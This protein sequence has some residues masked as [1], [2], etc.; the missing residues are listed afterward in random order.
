[1]RKYRVLIVDDSALMGEILTEILNSD[2]E[3]EVVGAAADPF[4]AR[5]LI[6]NFTSPMFL[7][8]TLKCLA[9]MG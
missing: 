4:I 2:P 1:M 6:S 8:S 7:R 5:D 3:I 9:W